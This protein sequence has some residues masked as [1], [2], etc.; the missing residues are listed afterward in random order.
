MPIVFTK[1]AGRSFSTNFQ[2]RIADVYSFFPELHQKQVVCGMIR[3]RRS[4]QGTATNWTDPPVFRLRPGVSRFTIAHE[5]T[6][7]VQGRESGIPHGEVACDIWT[8]DRMP[9]EYLDIRPYYLFCRIATDWYANRLV[10]KQLCRR[11]IELR[12]SM[13]TYISWLRY[14]I[15]ELESRSGI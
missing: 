10:V 9:A 8:I 7:L 3:K 13:R 6:H 1:P 11:A 14:R 5:L 15:K 12:K 2:E 4:V